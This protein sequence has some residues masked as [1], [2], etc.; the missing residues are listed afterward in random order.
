MR[1]VLYIDLPKWF[2]LLTFVSVNQ[3]NCEDLVT[4]E[5]LKAR[6]IEWL[7]CLSFHIYINNKRCVEESFQVSQSHVCCCWTE[8]PRSQSCGATQGLDH[9]TCWLI[10]GVLLKGSAPRHL[11]GSIM[12]TALQVLYL[13]WSEQLVQWNITGLIVYH[14][15]FDSWETPKARPEATVSAFEGRVAGETDFWSLTLIAM[16]R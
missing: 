11:H 10:V 5:H 16:Q 2:L 4:A 13:I 9:R 7:L 1:E 15:N 3:L 6:G 12:Q 14:P 8:A